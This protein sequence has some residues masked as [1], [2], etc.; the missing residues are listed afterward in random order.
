MPQASETKP[1]HESRTVLVFLAALVGSALAL[2][3]DVM[4][5]HA[6]FLQGVMASAVAGLGLR[7]ITSSGVSL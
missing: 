1:W 2:H 5:E 4:P 6:D 7:K 3:Y